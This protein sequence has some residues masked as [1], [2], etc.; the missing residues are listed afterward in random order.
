MGTNITMYTEQNFSEF[1]EKLDDPGKRTDTTA[2][3][4]LIGRHTGLHAQM[5]GTSIIGFG[6]YHYKYAS[7]QEVMHH[8]SASLRAKLAFRSTLRLFLMVK[9]ACWNNSGNIKPV[10]DAYIS[11][12]CLISI[13]KYY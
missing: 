4:S 2:L 6:T 9:P 12:N 11:K 5:W 13:L 3:M 7:G 10:R 1:I 8:W